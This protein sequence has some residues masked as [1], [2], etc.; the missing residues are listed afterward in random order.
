VADGACVA[1]ALWT[2]CCHA[3]V[4]LGGSLQLLVQVFAVTAAASVGL[5]LAWRRG[6]R[7]AA[8]SPVGEGAG[9]GGRG[10]AGLRG[11]GLGL[12]A[13]AALLL[14]G[15]SLILWWWAVLLLGGAALTSLR[16]DPPRI[17]PARR[18]GALELGLWALA[19]GGAALALVSHRVDIDDAFY[20]NLAVAAADAPREALLVGDTLHGV[21][22]LPIHLPVYR[23][24]S[25]EVAVG[26]LSWLTGL[27]AIAG[28]HWVGAGLAGLLVPLCFARLFRRLTPAVW[29]WTTA[30]LVGVLVVTGDTHQWYGN[31]SFV[32]IWQGKSIL[33]FVFLP[34]IQVYAI[35]FALRPGLRRWL[36]LAMAQIAALGCSATALWLAPA[37]ALAAAA[38]AAVP[39]RRGLLRL[40]LSALASIYVLGAGWAL[41]DAMALDRQATVATWTEEQRD[42]AARERAERNAPG[43]QLETALTQMTGEGRLRPALLFALLAA[44]AVCETGLARRFTAVVPLAMLVLI[45]NPYATGWISDNAVGPYYWRSLWALPVPTLLA[46]VLVAPLQLGGRWSHAGRAAALLAF[47]GF[48]ALVPGRS[49]LS[50]DNRVTLSRPH[51]KVDPDAYRW[52]GLLTESVAPGSVVVA[53]GWIGLWLPT[54][55][56]RVQPLVVRPHYLEPYVDELGV[57][58]LSGRIFMTRY[59]AGEMPPR[60]A[61]ARFRRGLEHFGVKAVCLRVHPRA[62]AARTT[63]REAGFELHVENLA[64][65]IWVRK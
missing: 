18:A 17:L 38:C 30:V 46:L 15:H 65:A 41:R 11:V 19:L 1:F 59:A 53:P 43:V 64:Y 14:A 27:P 7:T 39:T 50:S 52:A 26:A 33:L 2:V 22:G 5:G 51:L 57:E 9:Q 12:G 13:A 21:E 23:L 45:L 44:W 31:F 24:H 37:T 56:D 35:D 16:L 62:A 28:F 6:G 34:L 40:A 63:L 4:A 42:A 32:R 10:A 49:T 61:S 55:H 54:F 36:L 60:A 48:V 29:L 58:D 8:P 25:Y 3:V 20:V 47:I